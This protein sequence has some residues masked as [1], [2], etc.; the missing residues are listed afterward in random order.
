MTWNF[1]HVEGNTYQL[2]NLFSAKTFTP[3]ANKTEDG[4]ALEEQPLVT[5]NNAQQYEFIAAANNTYL[6]KIKGADLYITATNGDINSNIIL[7]KKN[8]SKN[9]RWTIYNQEPTM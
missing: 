2:Q 1:K 9:Q 3:V 6:I 5:A 7:V 4:V 8:N